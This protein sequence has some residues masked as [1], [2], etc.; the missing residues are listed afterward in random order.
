MK[1]L[2]DRDAVIAVITEAIRDQ[3]R[4]LSALKERVA[5]IPEGVVR[6]KDCKYLVTVVPN[7]EYG[8]CTEG[9]TLKTK[10]VRGY[11]D[12]GERRTDG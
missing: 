2:I 1:T 9:K 3:D 10:P 7:A 11:C 8:M 5:E 12:K 4:N 6:C